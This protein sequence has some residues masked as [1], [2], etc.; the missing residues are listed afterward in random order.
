MEVGREGGGLLLRPLREGVSS[1]TMT[2]PCFDWTLAVASG[3]WRQPATLT[4][5]PALPPAPS[6]VPV[7]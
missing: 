1:R 7:R 5:A 4:S 6:L 3:P 2:R